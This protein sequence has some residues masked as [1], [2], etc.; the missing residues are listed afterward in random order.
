MKGENFAFGVFTVDRRRKILLK[1]G[2]AVPLAQKAILLL[3]ALLSAD[4]RVVP[5]AELMDIAW[6]GRNVE[7]SNLSVQI[8]ALRKC[9]GTRSDGTDWIVTVPRVGYR[10]ADVQSQESGKSG[11]SPRT[12]TKQAD[13]PSIAVLSFE[14][15]SGDAAQDYFSSGFTEDVRTELTRLAGLT[16]I[17]RHPMLKVENV[18]PDPREICT[19]LNV[20]HVLMGSVRRANHRM[21]INVQ[22][23]NCADGS[24]LWSDRYDRDI[25]DILIVQEEIARVIAATLK[26]KLVED[27]SSTTD[28]ASRL[29]MTAYDYCLQA[30]HFYHMHTISHVVMAKRMFRKAV[31]F[32]PSYARA[33]AGLAFAGSFLYALH[34]P[35]GNLEEILE[36]STKSILLEPNL[37][38][39]H[40]AHGLALVRANRAKEATV[41]FDRAISLNP[42]LFEAHYHYT[43]ALTDLQDWESAAMCYR[44]ALEIAPEDY[45]C[46]L[47]LGQ[48]YRS[49]ARNAEAEEADRLGVIYAERALAAH[50]DVSLAATLG[51]GGLARLGERERSLEWIERALTIAPEDSLTCYNAAC[52]LSTL[53]ELERAIDLLE[54]WSIGAHPSTLKWIEADMDLDNLRNH[55][56]FIALFDKSGV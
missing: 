31:D 50:P 15:L 14:N 11:T 30:R 8:A 42:N 22:L 38:E 9:L 17:A 4:G 13:R 37:A 47:M 49:M 43:E 28:H 40:A 25:T 44:R 19:R 53:G 54:R 23:I 20:T 24:S 7:E 2:E 26:V 39:A 3:D 16:I 36:A 21:R 18:E 56:R 41:I 45:R 48:M 27:R 6:Q 29:N 55:P 46:Q 1:D 10:F 52:G 32:D 35:E 33:Y 12:L 34:H 51:A 5:K